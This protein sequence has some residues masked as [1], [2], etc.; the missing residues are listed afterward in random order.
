M[1]EKILAP[2]FILFLLLFGQA[3]V[4]VSQ[5]Y[6]GCCGCG[7]SG[8]CTPPGVNG[9]PWCGAPT[10]AEDLMVKEKI[11]GVGES[12]VASTETLTE[13]FATSV[14][15]TGGKFALKMHE[16][17]E[18]GL[19]FGCPESDDK[20]NIHGNIVFALADTRQ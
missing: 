7:M 12:F 15:G 2:M 3:T 17:G 6:A 8:R 13:R 5:A 10:P 18:K 9:C 14:R 16:A 11:K 19:K 20:T 1:R 4:V